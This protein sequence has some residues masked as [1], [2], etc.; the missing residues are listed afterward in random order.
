[1]NQATVFFWLQEKR[2]IE[3]DDNFFTVKEIEEGLHNCSEFNGSFEKVGK[4]IHKLYAFGYLEIK[5]P[6]N[7]R[8]A[9]RVK[10]SCL[11]IRRIVSPLA[12]DL[13]HKEQIALK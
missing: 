12:S 13:S 11:N 3:G 5:D 7:Y 8:R 4:F 10:D 2:T 1:M 9:Y 6:F